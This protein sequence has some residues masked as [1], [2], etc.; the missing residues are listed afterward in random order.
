MCHTHRSN[1]LKP[2]A[3]LPQRINGE[4]K[5]IETTKGQVDLDAVLNI[6]A[7][8]LEKVLEIEPDFMKVLTSSSSSSALEHQHLSSGHWISGGTKTS[9]LGRHVCVLDCSWAYNSVCIKSCSLAHVLKGLVHTVYSHSTAAH[10]NDAE[11][12]CR[13]AQCLLD[14]S[15]CSHNHPP[16]P[17]PYYSP[18]MTPLQA[19]HNMLPYSANV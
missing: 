4:A 19:P 11:P 8:S 14:H 16:S 7:F 15:D 17:A 13:I 5:I 10:V 18:C 2:C 1:I 6:N 9:S 3:W 12:L